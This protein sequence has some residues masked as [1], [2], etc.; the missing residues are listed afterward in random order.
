MNTQVLSLVHL[1]NATTT[2][3]SGTLAFSFPGFKS[4]SRRIEP[5]V[6]LTWLANRNCRSRALHVNGLTAATVV[7]A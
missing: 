7:S 2:H 4:I 3:Q 1:K 6:F 5:L